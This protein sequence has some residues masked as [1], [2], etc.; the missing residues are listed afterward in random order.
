MTAC[1]P[2][3]VVIGDR[4]LNRS[5]RGRAPGSHAYV[6]PGRGTVTELFVTEVVQVGNLFALAR[7]AD[8]PSLPLVR[9][10][11]AILN[12]AGPA[13][14]GQ[15]LL[16][17]L[18]FGP[19]AGPRAKFAHAIDQRRLGFG[20]QGEGGGVINVLRAGHGFIRD[21]FGRG[22]FFPFGEARGFAPAV[23]MAVRFRI[24]HGP[25]GPVAVNVRRA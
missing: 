25:R 15:L 4:G 13:R 7:V 16:V 2:Q 20:S 18:E 17:D 12:G 6:D 9:I 3:H 10:D 5:G 11:S 14:V 23:G 19:S 8:N 1:L 24:E 22:V 21:T